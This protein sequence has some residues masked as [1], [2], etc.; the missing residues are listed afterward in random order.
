MGAW[1]AGPF[2]NDDA[3][4]FLGELAELPEEERVD[5]IKATLDLPAGEYLDL[6]DGC[7]AIASA[8]LIGIARGMSAEGAD[9]DVLE[10]AQ[11]AELRADQLRSMA[12][13]ALSRVNGEDSEWRELWTESSSLP[14]AEEAIKL[15]GTGL[16]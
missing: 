10:L 3:L 14:E 4:D 5:R 16:S 13:L 11:S 15:I 12:L 9:E 7:M 1:G 2:E 8:G 6:P